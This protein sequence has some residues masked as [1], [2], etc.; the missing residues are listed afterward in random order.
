M[1]TWSKDGQVISADSF[2]VLQDQR[3]SV[4]GE[5]GGQGV[6]LTISG[7][8]R[9]DGGKFISLTKLSPGFNFLFPPLSLL[10]VYFEVILTD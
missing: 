9:S 1:V 8:R 3:I 7:L 4:K 2:K 6:S 5:Q 10:D